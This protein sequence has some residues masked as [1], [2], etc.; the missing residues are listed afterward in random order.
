MS[1]PDAKKNLS[2]NKMLSGNFTHAFS[3][4][5]IPVG[6]YDLNMT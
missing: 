2:E 1:A 6:G 3:N 4:K 5:A